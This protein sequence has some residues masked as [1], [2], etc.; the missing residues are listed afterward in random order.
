[1]VSEYQNHIE[2]KHNIDHLFH[3]TMESQKQQTP[4]TGCLMSQS[5]FEYI[6]K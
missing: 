4:L 3:I 6:N 5:I 1:M 2:L